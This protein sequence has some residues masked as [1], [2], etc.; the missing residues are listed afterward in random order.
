[1]SFRNK[2]LTTSCNKDEF[3]VLVALRYAYED[4][5]DMKQID[6]TERPAQ[7]PFILRV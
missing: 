2:I 7:I 5:I 6:N 1:M 4:K 3:D